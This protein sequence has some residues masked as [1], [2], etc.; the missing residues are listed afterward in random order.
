MRTDSGVVAGTLVRDLAIRQAKG[1]TTGIEDV[2]SDI[3]VILNA[4]R[5]YKSPLGGEYSI[6]RSG[7]MRPVS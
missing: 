7:K 6:R 5:A 1:I 3:S 4:M 2:R